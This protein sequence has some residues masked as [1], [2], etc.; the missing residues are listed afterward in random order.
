MRT[1]GLSALVLAT[2]I[3]WATPA[4]GVNLQ[5]PLMQVVAAGRFHGL[6][7]SSDGTVRAWGYNGY[8]QLG[9][10][11]TASRSAQVQMSGLGGVAGV[12]AGESH[13]LAV[14]NDGTALAL[15][16][17]RLRP[18]GRRGSHLSKYASIGERPQ[19]CGNCG[20]WCV[21]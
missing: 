21:S 8:S 7:R 9:D 20:R 14:K 16:L 17:H 6:K 15:G 18:V 4:T 19:R 13:S 10:G 1:W 3:V 2:G 11:T 5:S 12:A